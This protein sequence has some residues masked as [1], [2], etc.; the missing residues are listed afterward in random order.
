M[1][2]TEE[3]VVYGMGLQGGPL[4]NED[5]RNFSKVLEDEDFGAAEISAPSGQGKKEKSAW[6]GYGF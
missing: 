1:T 5:F 3:K 6:M 2:S 4:E